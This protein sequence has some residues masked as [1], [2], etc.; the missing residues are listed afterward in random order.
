MNLINLETYKESFPD[1]GS[2]RINHCREEERNRKFYLTRTETGEVIGYCHH[3]GGRGIHKPNY[4]E[5]RTLPTVAVDTTSDDPFKRWGVP[6]LATWKTCG[7]WETV[8]FG[9]LPLLT[10]KWW[11]KNGLNVDEYEDIGIRMLDGNRFTIPL[12][13]TLW[14][15]KVT[16]V[17]IRTFKDDLPKWIILGGKTV[18]PFTQ[19]EDEP[20]TLVLTEDYCSAIR[21]S[22]SCTA[23]P[24][25]GISLNSNVFS[26]ITKW[27][28]KG[29]RVVVWL[30]NDSRAVVQQ[31]KEIRRRLAL[32]MKCDIILVSKEPKHYIHDAELREVIHGD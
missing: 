26:L 10:R 32:T 3:C 18:Y 23:L 11:F 8:P 2:V 27:Y 28:K 7:R 22:R 21:V 24:L 6:S 17:A 5:R 9:D 29:R 16:G 1:A 15:N 31:A 14:W 13:S 19:V 20:D 4:K 25:M 30:D 12:R